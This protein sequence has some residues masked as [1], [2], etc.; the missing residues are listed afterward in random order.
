MSDPCFILEGQIQR[1]I[2][3]NRNLGSKIQSIDKSRL[4]SIWREESMISERKKLENISVLH[5]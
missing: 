1:N 3:K 5:F 4:I 2:S